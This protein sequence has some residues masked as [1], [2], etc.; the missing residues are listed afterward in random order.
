MIRTPRSRVR[1]LAVLAFVILGFGEGGR[2]LDTFQRRFTEGVR[3][4]TK[5][6]EIRVVG[7]CGFS[8]GSCFVGLFP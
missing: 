5:S 6:R 4:D 2:L 8:E 7:Y 1:V 3:G